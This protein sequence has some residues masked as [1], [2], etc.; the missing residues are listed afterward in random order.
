MEDNI[1]L[2]KVGF[3]ISQ[4]TYDEMK[5]ICEIK[6]MQENNFVELAIDDLC[7]LQRKTME[8]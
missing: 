1:P 8:E 5:K 3:L 4:E 7:F 2:V 6:N